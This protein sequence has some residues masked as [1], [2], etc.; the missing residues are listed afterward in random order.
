MVHP[1]HTGSHGFGWS[2]WQK[3]PSKHTGGRPTAESNLTQV[4]GAAALCG[5]KAALPQ[6]G[7]CEL[8]HFFWWDRNPLWQEEN[9]IAVLLLPHLIPQ[10]APEPQDRS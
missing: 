8:C 10:A 2:K 9:F 7:T 4:L 6:G 1:N 3:R 5:G